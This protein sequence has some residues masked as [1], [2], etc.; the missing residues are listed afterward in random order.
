MSKNGEK[1]YTSRFWLPICPALRFFFRVSIVPDEY[2]KTNT[3]NFHPMFAQF[4][5]LRAQCFYYLTSAEALVVPSILSTP[6]P[7]PRTTC[8]VFLRPNKSQ[9]THQSRG[10]LLIA[11]QLWFSYG[12]ATC[13]LYTR[14]SNCFTD[15]IIIA[16][17]QRSYSIND[18]SFDHRVSNR[19]NRCREIDRC[20]RCYATRVCVCIYKCIWEQLCSSTND[21]KSIQDASFQRE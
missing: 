4:S 3:R 21:A 15:V 11:V 10:L 16:I 5:A 18:P 14:E 6:H 12:C 7:S 2:F 19:I 20:T 1:L 17:V 13:I 8:I 9:L